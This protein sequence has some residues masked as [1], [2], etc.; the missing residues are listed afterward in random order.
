MD[1]EKISQYYFHKLEVL[2]EKID[3]YK[4]SDFEAA[5]LDDRWKAMDVYGDRMRL[6]EAQK[7]VLRNI[8]RKFKV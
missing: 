7:E 4:V 8:C 5:F 1:N 6:S 3:V 2:K